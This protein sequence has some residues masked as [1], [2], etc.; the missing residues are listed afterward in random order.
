MLLLSRT[1]LKPSMLAHPTG[2]A[3]VLC[4]DPHQYNPSL[5]SLCRGATIDGW[6]GSS[7]DP[8]DAAAV[9]S[10]YVRRLASSLRSFLTFEMRRPLPTPRPQARTTRGGSRKIGS[11]AL[12]V[13]VSRLAALRTPPLAPATA[14][15]APR[16]ITSLQPFQLSSSTMTGGFADGRPWHSALRARR[17]AEG[18]SVGAGGP[19]LLS[20]SC[21][22]R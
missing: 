2:I 18:F 9:A 1:Y 22:D 15:P 17:R 14:H 13:A 4:C 5:A 12:I 10:P 3:C 21:R 6:T 19:F 20:R 11:A 16:S 8:K 7:H